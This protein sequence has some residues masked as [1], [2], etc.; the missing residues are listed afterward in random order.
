MF[1]KKLCSSS[2]L[3]DAV[4]YLQIC[5]LF[6]VGLSE[7]SSHYLCW[8][9][10]QFQYSRMRWLLGKVL[11]LPECQRGWAC[12]NTLPVF[13]LSI[14]HLCVARILVH[15]AVPSLNSFCEVDARTVCFVS[16]QCFTVLFSILILNES[17]TP[18]ERADCQGIDAILICALVLTWMFPKVAVMIALI[19]FPQDVK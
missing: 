2:R 1:V 18:A 7:L 16:V 10:G 5:F 9:N 14:P 8:P 11:H 6:S 12:S 13:P 15:S 17:W 3:T 4:C 19:F